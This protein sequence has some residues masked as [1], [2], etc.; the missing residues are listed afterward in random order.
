MTLRIRHKVILPALAIILVLLAPAAY[1]VYSI[2]LINFHTRQLSNFDFP[3]TLATGRMRNHLDDLMLYGR[4]IATA[5]DPEEYLQQYNAVRTRF[6]AELTRLEEI[7]PAGPHAVQSE[8]EEAMSRLYAVHMFRGDESTGLPEAEARAADRLSALEKYYTDKV[9]RRIAE[10]AGM[11]NLAARFTL[12]ALLAAL[13]VSTI[14]WLVILL[15][16]SRPL[17]EL[18]AGTE[19]VA[20]GRFDEPIRVRGKDELG[21]LSVAFNKMADSLGELDRMKAEFVAT[22]S[23]ELKTPLACIKGF[24]SLLRSGSKGPLTDKQEEILVQLEEQ[25]DQL[26]GFVTQLLDLS[27][28]QAGRATMNMRSLPTEPFFSS[29]ARGFEGVADK[30]RIVFEVQMREGL[31]DRVWIDPD[32]LREVIYN[33]LG[34]AFKFT[35]A[36]GRVT[37]TVEPESEDIRVTVT[38]SG[39]G[40]PQEDL[41]FIFERYYK[42]NDGRG[43]RQGTGL[44]L[45]IARGIIEKHGGRIWVENRSEAG[46]CFVFRIPASSPVPR[47]E[48]EQETVTKES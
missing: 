31:P 35:D 36:E 43:E 9:T 25:A 42:G 44:G 13:V 10:V 18:V 28:L 26:T 20:V 6:N 40:I 1:S 34:N 2:Y 3:G 12:Y 23:H 5:S 24:A 27:R 29:V 48:A 17:K 11:G 30:Q 32:R 16:L 37:F 8:L 41:P 45:A 47:P 19:R 33:L 7:D 22:A 14:V 4:L 39:P 46:A 15:S 21:T 38:D